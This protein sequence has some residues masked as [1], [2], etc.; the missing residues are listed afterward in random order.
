MWNSLFAF[1]LTHTQVKFW[2]QRM[3]KNVF[4]WNSETKHKYTFK[5][6]FG[7]KLQR[8]LKHYL[9]SEHA[10]QG[11]RIQYECIV[12]LDVRCHKS[13]CCH[14]FLCWL[15]MSLTWE[16]FEKMCSIFPKC[17]THRMCEKSTYVEHYFIPQQHKN[18]N[19]LIIRWLLIYKWYHW[20]QAN[21]KLKT[22]RHVL[23]ISNFTFHISHFTFHTSH[24]TFHISHFTFHIS[25]FRFQISIALV[26]CSTR[27][28][29]RVNLTEK[30]VRI[31]FYWVVS[32]INSRETQ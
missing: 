1:D 20:V 24:F 16:L 28:V 29:F 31:K 27:D 10:S 13:L 26:V 25:D 18:K 23:Q 32:S 15:F 2:M 19:V 9:N 21:Y 6:E 17:N 3:S 7:I 14:I 8:L 30:L 5:I 4:D 22:K 11:R 12:Y